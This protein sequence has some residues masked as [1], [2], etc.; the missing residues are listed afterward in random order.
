MDDFDLTGRTRL[1]GH[2]LLGY[3][4]RHA[5]QQRG[6]EE[7]DVSAEERALMDEFITQLAQTPEWE[8][9]H[10]REIAEWEARQQQQQ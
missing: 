9:V 4:H 2:R 8:A 6:T 3:R 7:P 1:L 10:Q 5:H